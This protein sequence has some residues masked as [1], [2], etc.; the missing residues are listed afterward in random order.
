MDTEIQTA[1]TKGLTDLCFTEHW[2][3]DFPETEELPADFFSLDTEQYR[4]TF[5]REKEKY[6][7]KI[8][9]GYGVELGLQPQSAAKN[10]EIAKAG[11][12][13]FIIGSVH[14]C[15]G[16]DPYDPP[17]YAGRDA[18]EAYR[19]YFV[20]ILENL[21]V[22]HE[23]DVCGHLD[24]AVR[25][26]PHKDAD[27]HYEDYLDVIEEILKILIREGKGLEL[28]TGGLRKGMSDVHPC[29]GILRLYRA[30]G[31]EIV[32]VGSDA[33]RPEDIA[34]SFDRAAEVL[35]AC[36]FSAYAT[37]AGRKPEFHSFK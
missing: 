9:L 17:F 16:A 21:Q 30:M 13:D 7:G 3:V 36:G 32:T 31:G 23:Y 5:L 35:Q 33:H 18:K 22:F 11:N 34:A 2:D 12:F 29:T 8:R 28:N 37:Y 15:H 26:S 20:S 4:K 6:A 24:Y 19:E 1:L 14:L 27:Y 10:T 25:Y